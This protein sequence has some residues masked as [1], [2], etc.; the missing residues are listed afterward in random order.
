MR[1]SNGHWSCPDYLRSPFSRILDTAMDSLISSRFIVSPPSSNSR[2]AGAIHSAAS[3]LVASL[4]DRQT[5]QP[6]PDNLA[7]DHPAS[8]RD[9]RPFPEAILAPVTPH[10]L[11]PAHD[12]RQPKQRRRPEGLDERLAGRSHWNPRIRNASRTLI[13]KAMPRTSA[14]AGLKAT[15]PITRPVAASSIGPPLLPWFNEASVWI[16]ARVP[17]RFK[18]LTIPW[19]TVWFAPDSV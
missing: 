17:W 19:V 18:A 10:Q 12:P 9:R 3:I 4:A 1:L 13:P 15:T 8:R 16:T 14:G 6:A 7:P 2:S 11:E 5:D